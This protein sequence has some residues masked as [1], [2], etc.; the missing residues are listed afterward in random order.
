[1]CNLLLQEKIYQKRKEGK[2]DNGININYADESVIVRNLGTQA[3]SL[4]SGCLNCKTWSVGSEFCLY[5]FIL[6]FS[7]ES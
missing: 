1:M 3:R 4:T 5:F 6:L 7:L 2:E